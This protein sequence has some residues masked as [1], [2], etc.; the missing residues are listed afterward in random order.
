MAKLRA[1]FE[2]LLRDVGLRSQGAPIILLTIDSLQGC[3]AGGAAAKRDL[4][5]LAGAILGSTPALE[6]R[7][8][9][10][11]IEIACFRQHYKEVIIAG[12]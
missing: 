11:S 1:Q 3:A 7:V 10:T 4:K 8:C 12:R 9:C 2:G 6:Q 5:S